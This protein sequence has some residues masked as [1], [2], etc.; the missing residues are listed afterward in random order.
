MSERVSKL[1]KKIDKETEILVANHVHGGFI[2]ISQAK[3]S[4]IDLENFGNEEYVTFGEL[5]T[6]MGSKRDIL[7]DLKLLLLDV[8]DEDVTLD[9]VIASL[10]VKDTYAQLKEIAG[11]KDI[12]VHTIENFILTGTEKKL[13]EILSDPDSKLRLPILETA[14]ALQREGKL[15]DYNKM[16]IIA[17]TIESGKKDDT[18]A[19]VYWIDAKIPTV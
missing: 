7:Q 13:K 3:G 12:D 9:D 17:G 15:K 6:I 18:D 4:I 16:Q 8:E 1:A 5:K 14:V 2:Y 19:Q 11:K 10:R